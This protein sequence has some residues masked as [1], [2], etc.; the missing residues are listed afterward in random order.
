MA[1][2]QPI[3]LLT[4]PAAVVRLDF[5]AL[6]KNTLVGTYSFVIT[7][8]ADGRGMTVSHAFIIRVKIAF[9]T[10]F[11]YEHRVEETWRGGQLQELT[12]ETTDADGTI[13]V[14]ARHS[15]G[16]IAIEGPNGPGEAPAALLTTTCAWHPTFILQ[17]RVIDV[18]DGG[19]VALAVK[20]LGTASVAID[21]RECEAD[22]YAF[23]S[24]HLA[25]ALWYR[26]GSTLVRA[27]IEKK[28]HRVVLVAQP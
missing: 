1:A 28:G 16:T 9:I 22:H 12:A 21:G 11:S 13:H 10:M 6:W 25:G 26:H 7:P 14:R 2:G 15:A 20:A 27:E 4:P 18:S 8:S 19:I 17:D 3:A 23:T 5:Q 24:P